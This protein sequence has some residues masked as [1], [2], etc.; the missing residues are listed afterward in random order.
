M[1][2]WLALGILPARDPDSIPGWGTKIL[3][4]MQAA[5]KKKKDRLKGVVY[6]MG[7]EQYFITVN[8][9]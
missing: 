2:Q 1:V 9:K 4:A 5:K 7:E 6:N 8:G 3:Q